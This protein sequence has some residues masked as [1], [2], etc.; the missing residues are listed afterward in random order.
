LF[1]TGAVNYTHPSGAYFFEDSVMA[2][3]LANHEEGPAL[4]GPC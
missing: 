1:I 4:C 2:E 3:C